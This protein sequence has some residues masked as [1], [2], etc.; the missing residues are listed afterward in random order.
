MKKDITEFSEPL[1]KNTNTDGP[2]LLVS[3]IK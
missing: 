1:F 3:K 2:E